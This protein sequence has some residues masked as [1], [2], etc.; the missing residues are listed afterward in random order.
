MVRPFRESNIMSN[1]ENPNA[2]AT[3]NTTGEMDIC[4]RT[5]C[6]VDA[7]MIRCVIQ[8][9]LLSA[10]TKCEPLEYEGKRLRS[11]DTEAKLTLRPGAPSVE[12]LR[13]IFDAVPHAHYAA[14]TM[15]TAANYTGEREPRNAWTGA[16]ERP[17]REVLGVALSAVA[18]RQKVLE[19]ELDRM[20]KAYRTLRA[21]HDL[22]KRWTP[23]V[24]EGSSPGWMALVEQPGTDLKRIVM[25][26]APNLTDLRS[27]L[28][29]ERE[30][31]KRLMVINS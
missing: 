26:E 15:A 28:K 7:E 20:Q 1:Y 21:M 25:V 29:Q 30:V 11:S 19:A 4:L 18:T 10:E 22:G 16:V 3:D 31:N 8:P 17:T 23:P 9:W 27:P 5:E 2:A 13:Y 6:P 14:D 12:Q 24:G